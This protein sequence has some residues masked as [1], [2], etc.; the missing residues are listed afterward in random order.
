MKQYQEQEDKKKEEQ[1][2]KKDE[3]K[4]KL[5]KLFKN[6]KEVVD[7]LYDKIERGEIFSEVNKVTQEIKEKHEEAEK[8]NVINLKKIGNL[9]R[10]TGDDD[11]YDEEKYSRRSDSS[12]SLIDFDVICNY[13]K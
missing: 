13:K 5:L 3:D 11:L 7:N 1:E 4:K 10:L 2:R 8:N 12:D 6:D 9:I